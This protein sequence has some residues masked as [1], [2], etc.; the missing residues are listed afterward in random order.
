M[1]QHYPIRKFVRSSG[2]V[3]G[4]LIVMAFLHPVTAFGQSSAQP[5][6]LS[7][8]QA[9]ADPALR[10]QCFD[11]LFAK[12]T[13][14]PVNEPAPVIEKETVV[15]VPAVTVPKP[16]NFG[17]RE[18]TADD[19]TRP[20]IKPEKKRA[21]AK[22]KP[23]EISSISERVAKID[24]FGYKKLRITLENGQVWEQIGSVTNRPPKMSKGRPLTAEIRKAA[25]GSFSLRFDGKGRSIKVRRVT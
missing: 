8:C 24:I 11:T 15:P 16:E 9:M 13:P 1:A 19:L 14:A 20:V 12:T 22:A 23:P 21:L 10:L 7:D 5:L 25:F 4:C 2:P 3:A 6:T 18:T 17:K